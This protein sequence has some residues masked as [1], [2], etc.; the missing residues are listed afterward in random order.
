M[1]TDRETTVL[2]VEDDDV[3]AQIVRRALAAAS[4]SANAIQKFSVVHCTA[5]NPALEQLGK[6]EPDV[7]LLDLNLPDSSGKQTV[8]TLLEAC[9][10]VPVIALT[11]ME[12]DQL[13]L[14]A[15][16]CGAADFLCKSNIDSSSIVRAVRY[17]IER[18]VAR[19]RLKRKEEERLSAIAAQR[20]AEAKAALADD[21]R[22]AKEQAEAANQAKSDFLANMSHE[23]RTP[24]HGILSFARFGE[25]R[26]ETVSREKLGGYFQQVAASGEVLLELLNDLLDLS[27]LEAG[28]IDFEFEPVSLALRIQVQI[29]TFAAAAKD[30]Q[31]S[32][33]FYQ[34]EQVPHALADGRRIDQVFRNLLSNAVKFSPPGTGI[35]VRLETIGNQIAVSV[36]DRGPGIPDEEVETIFEKFSQSSATKTAA[37]GTGLGLAICREI[38]GGHNGTITAENRPE[39]GAK[40]TLHLPLSPSQENNSR[41][42]TVASQLATLA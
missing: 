18:R 19:D 5:L 37:G 29:A 14:E 39:G 27:K 25:R 15:V 16:R 31:V 30:K 20:E 35:E 1:K 4:C 7:V 6:A 11:G 42:T 23:L 41:P 12:D 17:A 24:L 34:S 38:V 3:D 26:F 28:R 9:S 10:R 40:F 33:V 2:L 36:S 8:T 21:L 22:F 13:A 32:I